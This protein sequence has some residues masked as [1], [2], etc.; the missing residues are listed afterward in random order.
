MIPGALELMAQPQV[1]V[2][3]CHWWLFTSCVTLGVSVN[4]PRPLLFVCRVGSQ[5]VS[6]T[7]CV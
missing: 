3:L 4:F 7:R 6:V 1:L 5:W 2:G